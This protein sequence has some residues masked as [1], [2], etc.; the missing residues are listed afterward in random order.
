[1]NFSKFLWGML[2]AIVLSDLNAQP[3][4]LGYTAPAG[5]DYAGSLD[6]LHWL[7][8]WADR[9]G[10]ALR[11]ERK[12]S[13]V[14]RWLAS[15][16]GGNSWTAVDTSIVDSYQLY[17]FGFV[18]NSTRFWVWG[19]RD[20]RL[21][22]SISIDFGR[23]FT[24]TALPRNFPVDVDQIRTV[25]S[26]HSVNPLRHNEIYSKISVIE[27]DCS[28]QLLLQS[29]DGG[30]NWRQIVIPG[31]TY[32]GSG[33]ASCYFEFS[34]LHDRRQTGH[35]YIHVASEFR[36]HSGHGENSNRVLRTT[37]NGVSFIDVPQERPAADSTYTYIFPQ[38]LGITR[39]GELRR[40]WRKSF[41]DL[42]RC[43]FVQ[44]NG[45]ESLAEN[46]RIV[47][48]DW[49]EAI[50]PGRA[51]SDC[52]SGYQ[53]TLRNVKFFNFDPSM[54]IAH[55]SEVQDPQD[56]GYHRDWLYLVHG[57]AALVSLLWES[58]DRPLLYDFFL[59]DQSGMLWL[60][61]EDPAR[62]SLNE[63][64][65]PRRSLWRRQLPVTSVQVF[66]P[67]ERTELHITPNPVKD[68]FY[69]SGMAMHND[70]G[71]KVEI[72]DINGRLIST[73]RIAESVDALHDI[74][75]SLPADSAAGVYVL[76]VSNGTESWITQIVKLP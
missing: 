5:W 31:L 30:K 50:Q 38:F 27:R 10:L 4:D 22:F 70:N 41:T 71:C 61:T 35:W 54:A 36:A 49:L 19:L 24:T 2:L 17:R 44:H 51:L 8:L 43:R 16:D 76:R 69:L 48:R 64:S 28:F 29:D 68:R 74:P 62:D 66:G 18:P 42:R 6:S 63:V 3:P 1:M 65:L 32:D 21:H 39:A 37:D 75:L 14:P 9:G 11:G 72:V 53:H 7:Q 57:E 59:D 45:F 33:L 20:D 40:Y 12:L 55:I 46:G 58:E 34:L 25:P 15:T 56:A 73:L 13:S 67:N 52:A 23:S 60:V 47:Q 26:I